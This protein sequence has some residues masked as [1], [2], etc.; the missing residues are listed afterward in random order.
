[1]TSITNDLGQTAHIRAISRIQAAIT[2]K[3]N[4]YIN[5]RDELLSEFK[6]KIIELLCR[7]E[8]L[9]IDI[10]QNTKEMEIFI[11]S[12]LSHNLYNNILPSDRY[13]VET[14]INDEFGI[15][16]Y[17]FNR[18]HQVFIQIQLNK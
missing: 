15:N 18:D 3:Q 10:I 12:D 13:L 4:D 1:M 2:N 11:K 6:E 8:E 16:I 5:K 17:T 7:N 9:I 14:Q